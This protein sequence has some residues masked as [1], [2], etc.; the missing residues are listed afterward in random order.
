MLRILCKSCHGSCA[1]CHYLTWVMSYKWTCP[2]NDVFRHRWGYP[3]PFW[4]ISLREQ[5]AVL[6]TWPANERSL[7]VSHRPQ[8]LAQ[9]VSWHGA[10]CPTVERAGCVESSKTVL[11]AQA[12][13]QELLT[14]PGWSSAPK[15][16]ICQGPRRKTQVTAFFF[17]NYYFNF[18]VVV[19]NGFFFI[20]C[21]LVAVLPPS[22]LL[23]SSSIYSSLFLHTSFPIRIH[24]ISA[25]H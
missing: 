5:P 9:W 23:S 12:L 2:M 16:I 6:G 18:L 11:L 3:A 14:W 21:I 13:T 10:Q 8:L 4:L 20:Y 1:Y 24:P 22:T 19:E 7:P 25:T 17:L 15:Q